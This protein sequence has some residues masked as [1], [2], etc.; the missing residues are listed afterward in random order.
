MT[1]TK[2]ENALA[3]AGV[4][5]LSVITFGGIEQT[6]LGKKAADLIEALLRRPTPPPDVAKDQSFANAVWEALKGDHSDLRKQAII[7]RAHRASQDAPSV[8]AGWT[9]GP[10]CHVDDQQGYVVCYCPVP[11]SDDVVKRMLEVF[12]GG[13]VEEADDANPRGYTVR[14]KPIKA[15]RAAIAALQVKP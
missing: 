4:L 11:P 1:D 13:V 14:Y 12:N 6:R 15:M 2:L 8:D 7:L 5:R 3:I 10:L 9:H